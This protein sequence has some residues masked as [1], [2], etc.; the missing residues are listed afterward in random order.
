[1]DKK[2]LNC[3]FIINLARP[4]PPPPP[5]KELEISSTANLEGHEQYIDIAGDTIIQS[6]HTAPKIVRILEVKPKP[7]VDG[8]PVTHCPKNNQNL[9]IKLIKSQ[10]YGLYH[11]VL[12]IIRISA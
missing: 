5:K 3:S 6:S 8:P 9:I 12:K 2:S 1:M 10:F 7:V 11:T 4:A